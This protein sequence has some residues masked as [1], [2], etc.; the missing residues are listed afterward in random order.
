[1]RLSPPQAPKKWTFYVLRWF[2]N[3]K[4]TTKNTYFFV[5]EKKSKSSI[6]A[7]KNKIFQLT[8]TGTHPPT[9]SAETRHILSKTRHILSK[10]RHILSKTRHNIASRGIG[11]S[12]FRLIIKKSILILRWL[13]VLRV[14]KELTTDYAKKAFL[15]KAQQKT[16]YKKRPK[17]IASKPKKVTKPSVTP[18]ATSTD[19][20][21]FL[22]GDANWKQLWEY[23]CSGDASAPTDS[24]SDLSCCRANGYRNSRHV[25]NSSSNWN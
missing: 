17:K 1:M 12:I 19:C 16:S 2:S 23:D 3:R 24:R 9:P 10:T 21:G 20:S 13:N 22:R 7:K 25:S 8:E 15:T 6:F 18:E 11:T 4:K 14:C 5:F